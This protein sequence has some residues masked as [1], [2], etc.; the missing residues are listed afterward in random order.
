MALHKQ[1]TKGRKNS[2]TIAACVYMTCRIEG[3]PRKSITCYIILFAQLVEIVI[4]KIFFH[5]FADRFQ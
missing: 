1:L 5:R 4:L 2:L 3:T